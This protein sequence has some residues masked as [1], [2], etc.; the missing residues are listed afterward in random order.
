MHDEVI[1]MTTDGIINVL[2]ECDDGFHEFTSP[3]IPGFY[4]V[5]PQDDLETAFADVPRVIEELIHGDYDVRVTV[6]QEQTYSEY[7][8]GLPDTHKPVIRNYYVE[9]LAA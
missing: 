8:D 4:L 5:V 9:R 1:A 7:V 3:Q 2:H 6:K